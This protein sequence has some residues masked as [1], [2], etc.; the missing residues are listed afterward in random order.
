[1]IYKLR[2]CFV[3]RLCGIHSEVIYEHTDWILIVEF[4]TY[5]DKYRV[6]G[7]FSAFFETTSKIPLL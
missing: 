3:D 4:V 5:S 1:M 7:G 6:S 2:F